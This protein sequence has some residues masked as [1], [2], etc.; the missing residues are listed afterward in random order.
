[1]GRPC[2]VYVITTNDIYEFPVFIGTIE[3]CS[4]YLG[5]A[6]HRIRQN[7]YQHE[8]CKDRAWL[9]SYRGFRLQQKEFKHK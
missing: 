7:I 6:V 4:K 1:M 5:I 9:G 3:E 2:A 8:R